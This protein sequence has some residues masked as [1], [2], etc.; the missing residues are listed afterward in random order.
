MSEVVDLGGRTA[1]VTGASSGIGEAVVRAL[2]RRGV[3]TW[4][5]ARRADR[6][7]ALCRDVARDESETAEVWPLVADLRVDA[8]RTAMWERIGQGPIDILVNN[9]GIGF[10]APLTSGA[11]EEWLAMLELNVLALAVCTREAIALMN[12]DDRAGHIVHISSMS[13]H[14]VTDGGGMY[15]ATKMA[16][17]SLTESLRRE[18]REENSRIRISAV[19]PGTVVTEFH[20]RLYGSEELAREGYAQF[21]PLLAGDVARAVVYA[22]EQPPHVQVH[23][24]LVRAT[25]QRT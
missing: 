2:A 24:V 18:L 17:R 7:Q 23:D 25:E 16:V 12:R 11:T 6:L 8:D 1:V 22:V 19:S 4:A 13:G 10:L 3:H 14:R 21:P 15:G 20:S 9:A 5:V